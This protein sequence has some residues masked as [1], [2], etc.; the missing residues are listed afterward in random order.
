MKQPQLIIALDFATLEETTCFLEQFSSSS[1]T[2][3]IGM[4]LFYRYG[5]A[6]IQQVQAMGHGIFLDLK[7]HD[8]PNTVYRT[9]RNLARYNVEMITVHAT[10]GQK[11]IQAAK[12]GLQDGGNLTTKIIAVTQLTSISQEQMQ[13]E[14]GILETLPQNVLRLARLAQQ[15]GAEGV[16]SSVHEA[17]IIRKTCGDDF[18]IITPGIRLESQQQDDQTR[19][20]TPEY[21]QQQDSDVLVIG[22]AL[23]QASQPVQVYHQIQHNLLKITQ[24]EEVPSDITIKPQNEGAPSDIMTKPQKE[25]TVGQ[26]VAE[27]LLDIQAVTLNLNHYYTWTSGVRSPIYCDN[28][29][30]ISHPLIRREIIKA[31]QQVILEKFPAVTVIAGTATAGIP[32]AAWLSEQLNMPMIYVRGAKKEH[33]KTNQIEGIVQKGDR[34]VIVEDLISTGKSSLQVAQALKNIGVEVLG[35]VAIFSYEMTVAKQV[36]SRNAIQVETLTQFDTLIEVAQQKEYINQMDIEK[37]LAWRD[38]LN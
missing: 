8:I 1:L 33:G 28:R 30:I 16:V 11:M 27:M 2:V 4:E 14:Q 15:A 17:Q 31:F 7:L 5:E 23:T 37:L 29:L 9:M 26:K 25:L 13:C 3:K 6:I 34:V 22:R 36:F 20:A 12:K 24:D 21:A 35:I 19:I 18:L 10:G 32:H 38:Q